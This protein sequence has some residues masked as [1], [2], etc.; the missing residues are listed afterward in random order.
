MAGVV[1]WWMGLMADQP[2]GKYHIYRR[3]LT[4]IISLID[5]SVTFEVVD[6]LGSEV[7]VV[8]AQC[9]VKSGL[10]KQYHYY[11]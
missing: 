1:G 6:D 8:R 4:L 2:C 7:Q 11:M 9:N 5:S 3:S 10:H